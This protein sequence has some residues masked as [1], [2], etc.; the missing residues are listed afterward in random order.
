MALFSNGNDKRN[1]TNFPLTSLISLIFLLLNLEIQGTNAEDTCQKNATYNKCDG[2]SCDMD[3][4]CASR[5][6]RSSTCSYIMPTWEILIIVFFS[7]FCLLLVLG[8]VV[9]ACKNC[10]N[11]QRK[12]SSFSKSSYLEYLRK[13]R[14]KEKSEL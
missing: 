11:K 3:S 4:E 6:C 14:I 2:E 9:K 12:E 5:Y 1:P 10:K 13:Q 7:L 8:Q